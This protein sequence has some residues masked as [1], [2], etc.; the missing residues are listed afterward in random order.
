M[1]LSL[2]CLTERSRR[3]SRQAYSFTCSFMIV[4]EEQK[5]EALAFYQEGILMLQESGADSLPGGGFATFNYTGMFRDTKD[6]DVFCR[7][8]DFPKILKHF[9]QM[10]YEIQL[11]DVRWL[12]KIFKGE[13][14]IDVIFNSVNNIC[15]V[16]ESWFDH[17]THG[18][19]AGLPVKFLSA[20]DLIWCKSYVQNRERYVPP[21][22]TVN[23]PQCGCRFSTVMPI[24]V[25]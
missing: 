13:Y 19:F 2:A 1:K 17:A 18:E 4:T 16:D 25:L 24:S 22:R 11:T 6:L 21:S 20:E 8:G 10:G 5:L 15:T 23:P 7:P 9:S 14:F 3:A 12:A